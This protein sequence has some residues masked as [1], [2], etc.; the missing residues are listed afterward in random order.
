MISRKIAWFFSSLAEC[1]AIL[2]DFVVRRGDL[3]PPRWLINGIGGGDYAAAGREFFNYFTEIGGL[4]PEHRVLDVGCGCGRMAVPL[5]PYLSGAGEYYGFDIVPDAI[6]WSQKHIAA[7]YPRFHFELAN[8]YNKAY[9]PKGLLK[10]QEYRFP[11]A[12]DFFDFTYLTSVFTHMFADDVEHYLSEIA[13]TLKPGG[14]CMI[15][16]F[17]LNAEAKVLIEQGV[18][19]ILFNHALVNCTTSNKKTPEIAIAFEESFVRQSFAKFHLDILEPI[20]FGDWSGRKQA[21][22]HQDVILAVKRN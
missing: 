5:I 1:A 14:R 9:N 7:R 15:S 3:L 17:L 4:K 13:R 6:N 16:F 18:S 2:R 19:T 10:S 21:L 20:R 11:Y 12:D 8:I 22:S